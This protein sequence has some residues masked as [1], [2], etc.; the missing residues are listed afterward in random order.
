MGIK[1]IFLVIILLGI[2][3]YFGTIKFIYQPRSQEVKRLLKALDEE[4]E[5]NRIFFEITKIKEDTEKHVAQELLKSEKDLSWLLGKISETFKALNLELLSL[6]PQPLERAT[7]YTDIPVKV[8]T[9]C[10]YHTLGELVSR[11][12]NSDKFIDVGYLEMKTLRE[13]TPEGEEKGPKKITSSQRL[14][15]KGFVLLDIVLNI[16]CFYPHF[17]E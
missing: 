15:S 10:S 1:K 2:S 12:E 9:V 8:R 3:V 7:Y 5:K 14:D 4:Y 6:E 17:N 13:T 11:L 16:H